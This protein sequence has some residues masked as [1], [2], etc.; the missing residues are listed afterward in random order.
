MWRADPHATTLVITIFK[1]TDK[2]EPFFP[3]QKV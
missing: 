3:K 1:T 2:I